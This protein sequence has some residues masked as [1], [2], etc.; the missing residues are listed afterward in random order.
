[1]RVWQRVRI[2]SSTPPPCRHNATP[3]FARHAEV[4]RHPI[5]YGC[6]T[7]CGFGKGC[8]FCRQPAAQLPLSRRPQLPQPRLGGLCSPQTPANPRPAFRSAGV[9]PA[10]FVL[11]FNG[12]LFRVPHSLRVSQRAGSF[13]FGIRRMAFTG[14]ALFAGLAKGAGF[15]VNLPPNCRYP[16][17]QLPQTFDNFLRRG[18]RAAPVYNPRRM[19]GLQ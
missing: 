3:Q 11:E 7:L 9:S 17:A 5:F 14:A 2:F 15:A 10:L 1:L 13:R 12:W 18:I 19:G 4:A 6:H 8:G 16:A